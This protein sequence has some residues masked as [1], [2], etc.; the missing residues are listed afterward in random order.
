[1]Q[2]TNQRYV[3][4][5]QMV[6]WIKTYDDT[7]ID[8]HNQMDVDEFYN[9]LFD[10]WESQMASAGEKNAFRAFYGGQLVQQ[11]RSKECDH[12]SER[13]EPFSAIQCDIKGKTTLL[14]SLRDYVDGE[15]M[16]GD[17]PNDLIFHLKR[18]DFNLRT[19]TRSKINDYFSFP[20]R[21]D[22]RPYTVEFLN[23]ESSTDEQDVFELV[24][25]LVHSGTAESGHY[26]SYIRER[27]S[28][29]E[30]ET[31]LEFNDEA[32]STWDSAQLELATFGGPDVNMGS[33]VN[34][35]LYD[36]TYSAYMLFYQRSSVLKAA[37]KEMQIRDLA[38]PSQVDIMPQLHDV[39]MNNNTVFLR[40]HCLFDRSHA[41]FVLQFFESMTI[42]NNGQCS[43]EHQTER[44][45][46]AML[47]GHLDQVVGRV[48]TSAVFHRYR[49]SLQT[50]LRNCHRC[51]K[52]FLDYFVVRPEAFRQLVQRNPEPPFRLA[53]GDML[54]VALEE[55][56]EH[57]PAYY[58]PEAPP[59]DVVLN[60]QT[61]AID[62]VL[63][64]FRRI[65]ENFHCNL[66]SWN[67]CFHLIL[68]FAEL[69]DA[70]TAALLHDDWLKD[71]MF[72]IAADANYPGLPEH[73]AMLVRGLSRRMSNKP[74][75][76]EVIIQL[77]NH[78]MKALE[79]LV[80]DDMVEE[81]NERLALHIEASSQ[82]LPWTSE[83]VNVLFAEDRDYG[84]S[85]F[86]RRLIEIDQE[87]ED[88]CAIICRLAK[89]DEHMQK[90]VT[91][92]LGNMI[93]GKAE[94]HSMVP[95]L[96]AALTFVCHCNEPGTSQQVL[97]HVTQA[98]RVLENNEGKSFLDFFQLAIEALAS[99]PLAEAKPGLT[100]HLE[101]LP[102]WGPGLI[103][104]LDKRSANLAQQWIENFL[105]RHQERWAQ[106]D[107]ELHDK[108]I[109][110]ARQLGV[111]C[112]QHLQE[113]YVAA[114]RQ[115]VGSTI[116]PLHK[117]ILVSEQYFEM[118]ITGGVPQEAFRN[119]KEGKP[120]TS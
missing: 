105:M 45:A 94:L 119:L 108:G 66:R 98:C 95:F 62:G 120:T 86:V 59:M 76:Y 26:Y 111:G 100:T 31:W 23:E 84:G 55:I 2:E 3:D 82:P 65:F 39:I 42:G 29:A 12:I 44:S 18:F 24:G 118:P 102:L 47:L 87:P 85:F 93:S 46:M 7:M 5:S 97:R 112:L 35:V 91:R 88:T 60:M 52:A 50:R 8:I 109:Q 116:E 89:G 4:T 9:L 64:L 48:K 78:L 6:S 1:M 106:E 30:T 61:S 80:Q 37:R 56:R 110:A 54:I 32:V 36:K 68:R 73:Y 11:V 28:N 17:I 70:E 114:E 103:G 51:A 58:G 21:I 115:V 99:M 77:I 15:I 33:D 14:D 20:N 27:P 41:I 67:E 49:A 104:C 63:I 69:G 13:L 25:V 38:P 57:N 71:L 113:Q 74:P 96:R 22:M 83:E 79:P 75:S 117:M 72:I 53:I 19:L 92:V 43:P 40:R 90:C 101:L 107:R 81:A 16:E 34:S 10:R